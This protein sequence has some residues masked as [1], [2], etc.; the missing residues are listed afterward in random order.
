MNDMENQGPAGTRLFGRQQES[1]ATVPM[2]S[3]IPYRCFHCD[4]TFEDKELAA[5]HFGTSQIQ[6][7]A[8]TIDIA[9]YR[10]MEARMIAYNEEDAD[11]HREMGHLRSTHATELKRE[12]ETGYARGLAD[13]V[14]HPAEAMRHAFLGSADLE[15]LEDFYEKC[16]DSESGGYST[17]KGELKRLSEIGV[18]QSLGFGR[19]GMTS[20][21]IFIIE[22]SKEQWATLPLRTSD[23]YAEREQAG[24][25]LYCDQMKPGDA[26]WVN[27][28]NDVRN[29]WRERAISTG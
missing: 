29:E 14:K 4:E 19:F 3:D 10:S 28:S 27:L 7:P 26:A 15:I 24:W 11:I 25:K 12:E 17:S 16:N 22:S 2:A 9:E 23:E 21:G 20:F 8:C 13:A 6:N 5:R 1:E 18:V